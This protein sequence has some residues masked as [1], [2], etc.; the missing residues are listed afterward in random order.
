MVNKNYH[1]TFQDYKLNQTAFGCVLK[2]I[3]IILLLNVE[4]LC[5]TIWK[6]PCK[7][8][9]NF[10]EKITHIKNPVYKNFY[11]QTFP[12]FPT[13]FFTSSQQISQTIFSTIPQPLLLQL[14]NIFNKEFKRSLYEN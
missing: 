3:V 1:I 4:I 9:A 5:K 13:I 14:R 10:C 6:S 2:Y 12:I 8:R 7:F 11:P